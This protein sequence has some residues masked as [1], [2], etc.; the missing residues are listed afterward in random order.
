M[1]PADDKRRSAR[2][3]LLKAAQQVLL[4]WHYPLILCRFAGCVFGLSDTENATLRPTT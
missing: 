1:T 2:I 4:E 3:I